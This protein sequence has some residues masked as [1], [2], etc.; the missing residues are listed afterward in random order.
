MDY[1]GPSKSV[2]PTAILKPSAYGRRHLE[3]ALHPAR[4]AVYS[5]AFATRL[6]AM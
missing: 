1:D 4:P 3:I 5:P 6:L 2:H